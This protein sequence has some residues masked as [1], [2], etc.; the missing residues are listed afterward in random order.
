MIEKNELG[1]SWIP[2][3]WFDQNQDANELITVI[4]R[5]R[6]WENAVRIQTVEFPSYLFF[7]IWARIVIS[8]ELDIIICTQLLLEFLSWGDNLYNFEWFKTQDGV[9]GC[10][11]RI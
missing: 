4:Q 1:Q 3:D 10:S 6:C 9:Y 11:L 5:M 8:L 2:S 7:S